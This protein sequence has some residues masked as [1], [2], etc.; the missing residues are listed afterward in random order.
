[1]SEKKQILKASS[2]E[3][4]PSTPELKMAPELK[5]TPEL[6]R[7]ILVKQI[8][9]LPENE[10]ATP[11]IYQTMDG[12]AGAYIDIPNFYRY[13]QINKYLQRYCLNIKFQYTPTYPIHE[14]LIFFDFKNNSGMLTK[15]HLSFHPPGRPD[16][17]HIKCGPVTYNYYFISDV[18]NRELYM[19]QMD[20]EEPNPEVNLNKIIECINRI[21]YDNYDK[22]F[23][24][25]YPFTEDQLL[26]IKIAQYETFK[27]NYANLVS[28]LD[29]L[30][31]HETVGTNIN[32]QKMR[33]TQQRM[34]ELI[35]DIT[36]KLAMSPSEFDI[37][38]NE[39]NS[40]YM[41][42]YLKYKHKY[43]QLKQKLTIGAKN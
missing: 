31:K 15:A 1:M 9:Q 20:F 43:L 14:I 33:K 37:Y 29:Y 30:S 18:Y 35:A 10:I 11:S 39:I 2:P 36:G 3:F 41:K 32:N 38:L 4:K 5:A 25:D 12:A 26:N 28:Y 8:S 27:Y 42:K 22:L 7:P 34:H 21:I 13:L 16:A 17:T 19:K 6:K 23:I 40:G 24:A